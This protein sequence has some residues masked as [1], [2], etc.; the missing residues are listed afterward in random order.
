[1]LQSVSVSV[2]TENVCEGHRQSHPKEIFFFE[3][4]EENNRGGVKGLIH[5]V[6]HTRSVSTTIT[7][8]HEDAHGSETP[9]APRRW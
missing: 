1:M 3:V 5:L 4:Q 6:P 9:P 8:T 2:P 7:R